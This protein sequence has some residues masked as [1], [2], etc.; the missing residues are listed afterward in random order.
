MTGQHLVSFD[1]HGGVTRILV[2]TARN[3]AHAWDVAL[4]REHIDETRDLDPLGHGT[5]RATA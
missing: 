5:A 4:Q 2:V 1:L 3:A